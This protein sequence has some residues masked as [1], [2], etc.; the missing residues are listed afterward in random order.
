MEIFTTHKNSNIAIIVNFLF[1]YVCKFSL[2]APRG[3]IQYKNAN[4][5]NFGFVVPLE[6][7]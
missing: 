4:I 7:N 2:F 3:V 6:I 1:P 5:A